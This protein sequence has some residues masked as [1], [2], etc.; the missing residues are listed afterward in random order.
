MNE[1]PAVMRQRDRGRDGPAGEREGEL[2]K[3]NDVE[4]VANLTLR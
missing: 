3:E 2:E 1:S 4:V